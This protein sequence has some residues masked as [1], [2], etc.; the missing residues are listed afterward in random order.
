MHT[1][2]FLCHDVGL[3]GVFL[4][5]CSGQLQ[6]DCTKSADGKT[7]Q[8]FVAGL[9]APQTCDPKPFGD[10]IKLP[11]L[12]VRTSFTPKLLRPQRI[13]HQQAHPI[14]IIVLNLRSLA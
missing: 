4:G 1:V 14:S 3:I 13:H 11:I 7:E 5:V 12:M 9:A 10:P 6:M 2:Q 8:C